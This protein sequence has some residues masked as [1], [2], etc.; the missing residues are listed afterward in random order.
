MTE[1]YA[2]Y[3][4]IMKQI[5]QSLNWDCAKQNATYQKQ[6][7]EMHDLLK[8]RTVDMYYY[9]EV[10]VTEISNALRDGNFSWFLNHRDALYEKLDGYKYQYCP[11]KKNT[12]DYV[13]IT[14]IDFFDCD[15]THV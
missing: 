1:A 2:E 11:P 4:S 12:D 14:G 9:N 7:L 15:K 13:K 5:E 8:Q 10:D 3:N 6:L